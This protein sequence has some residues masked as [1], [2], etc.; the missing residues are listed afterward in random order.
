MAKIKHSDMYAF[1][2]SRVLNIIRKESGIS[3]VDVAKRIGLSLPSVSALVN[4]LVQDGLII[5]TGAGE[6]QG[7]RRPIMLE[8]EADARLIIAIEIR[9]EYVRG[10]LCN[11][12]AQPKDIRKAAFNESIPIEKKLEAA[13]NIVQEL[14]DTV[15]DQ[16][17]IIGIGIAVTGVID[18]KNRIIRYSAPLNCRN[19]HLDHFFGKFSKYPIHVNNISRCE[20]LAEKWFGSGKDFSDFIFIY[21]GLGI[22]AGMITGGT[23]YSQSRYSAM[24]IGHN[25][26]HADGEQCRC[27]MKGCLEAY[28]ALWSIKKQYAKV[29][30]KEHIS[31]QDVLKAIENHDPLIKPI[32]DRALYYLGIE[33]ANLTNIFNPEIVI[34]DGWIYALGSEALE[35]LTKLVKE[36]ALEGLTDQFSII[37]ST[38][39]GKGVI[40]GAATTVLE[41]FFQPLGKELFQV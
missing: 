10:M 17:K 18:C 33:I 35:Y 16:E 20:A 39:T 11:L 28:S 5:E 2:R 22:G 6:S 4:S 40:I 36:R 12:N 32:V 7:G 26:V 24:E 9:Q 41:S 8:F 1:N 13:A 34:V 21:A 15:E 19:I 31:E 38:L 30:G 27:G 3:R 25:T 37:L 23:L 14:I 29:V